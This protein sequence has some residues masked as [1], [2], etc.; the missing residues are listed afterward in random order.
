MQLS[1]LIKET[2]FLQQTETIAE[3]NNWSICKGQL[4]VGCPTLTPNP[5]GAPWKRGQEDHKPEDRDICCEMTSSVYDRD[6]AYMK[7][8]KYSHLN[9][10]CTVMPVDIPIWMGGGISEIPSP[11]RR[12]TGN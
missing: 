4:S 7:S 12:T 8:Q 11:R 10:N 2:P 5:Q 3:I 1:C 6:T 9:M